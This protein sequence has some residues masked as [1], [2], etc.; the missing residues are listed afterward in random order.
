MFKY[1]GYW[2]SIVELGSIVAADGLVLMCQATI[3][4]N[5]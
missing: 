5:S 1:I 4:P 2:A 3:L